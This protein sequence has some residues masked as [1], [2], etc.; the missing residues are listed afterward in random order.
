MYR[1]IVF[2]CEKVIIAFHIYVLL[3]TNIFH[4]QLKTIENTQLHK[5]ISYI[6]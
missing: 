2:M 4:Q 5:H 3:D 1:T 6:S